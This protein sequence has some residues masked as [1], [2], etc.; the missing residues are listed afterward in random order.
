V[1]KEFGADSGMTALVNGDNSDFGKGYTY[2]AVAF[3][4]KAEQ[5]V[6][7]VSFLY[8]EP[9][10]LDMDGLEFSRAYYCFRFSESSQ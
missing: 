5:G 1:R 2:I 3:L 9:K 6:V 4:Y 7:V 8:N 10:D